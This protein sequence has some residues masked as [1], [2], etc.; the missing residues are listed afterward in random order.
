MKRNS[1]LL[2]L[3]YVS[4][5]LELVKTESSNVLG[6]KLLGEGNCPTG[7]TQ[8]TIAY[9]AQ[10]VEACATECTKVSTCKRFV[11]DPDEEMKANCWIKTSTCTMDNTLGKM[12][13]K[14]L[15]T[16]VITFSV[17]FFSQ[18]EIIII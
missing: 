14:K 6:Y 2:L 13:Y 18:I 3:L 5:H 1:I 12:V 15:T 16:G 11:Y 9:T 4:N 10:T 17:L 8:P 7:S